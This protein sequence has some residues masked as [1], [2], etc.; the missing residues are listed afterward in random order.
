[1]TNAEIL[2][3]GLG[4]TGIEV[5]IDTGWNS[6]GDHSIGKVANHNRTRA[7]DCVRTHLHPMNDGGADAQPRQITQP[8]TSSHRSIRREM[9][10]LTHATIM[11]DDCGGVDD[12]PG[13]N[14]GIGID[15][16]GSHDDRAPADT[17]RRRQHR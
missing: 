9:R 4:F 8:G 15:D 14:L 7:D 2:G 6:H 16:C 10:E 17:S 1:M 11:L 13:T 3:L 12:R 5:T